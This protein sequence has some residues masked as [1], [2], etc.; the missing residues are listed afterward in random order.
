MI[1]DFSGPGTPYNV[2][3]GYSGNGHHMD[4]SITHDHGYDSYVN[5]GNY[6][7]RQKPATAYGA[8]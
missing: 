1:Q 3:G 7:N 6:G 2:G 4:V 8:P 5:S